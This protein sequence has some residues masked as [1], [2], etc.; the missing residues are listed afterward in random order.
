M[1][2]FKELADLVTKS[3]D[4]TDE[5]LA[6]EISKVVSKMPPNLLVHTAAL[7]RV[8]N[9]RILSHCRLTNTKPEDYSGPLPFQIFKIETEQ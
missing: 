3:Y 5:L 9:K 6:E 7:Q 2:V 8:V 4:M 1:T